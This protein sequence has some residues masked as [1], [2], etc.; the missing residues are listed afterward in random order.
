MRTALNIITRRD[1]SL[2][3]EIFAAQQGQP[4]LEV[5]VVD[6]T[7]SEPDYGK[8]LEDIFAADSVAVW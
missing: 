3:A 6:L 8:L 5:Q 2:S 7:V 4:D 1:D